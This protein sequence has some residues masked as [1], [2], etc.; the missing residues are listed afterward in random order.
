MQ[1]AGQG[2][3][4]VRVCTVAPV[5]NSSAAGFLA[6]IEQSGEAKSQSGARRYGGIHDETPEAITPGRD[7]MWA[8]TRRHRLPAPRRWEPIL[9]WGVVHRVV[10]GF[11]YSRGE[12]AGGLAAS[13]GCVVGPPSVKQLV[14][15]QEEYTHLRVVIRG[16]WFGRVEK[17]GGRSL[18][19]VPI[20]I[21]Q[22]AADEYGC[23]LPSAS[24]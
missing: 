17:R 19:R 9:G 20:W 13:D 10:W 5:Y 23:S 21:E 1:R 22:T 2:E 3:G 7:S 16:K 12:C 6:M 24:W 11:K 18:F 14:R 15:V 4:K 8:P